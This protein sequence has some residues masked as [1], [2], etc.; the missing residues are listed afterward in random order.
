MD[1]KEKLEKCKFYKGE[2]DPYSLFADIPYPAR[3]LSIAAWKGEAMWVND[4]FSLD[5]AVS[6]SEV[7][8]FDFSSVAAPLDLAVCL[9]TAFRSPLDKGRVEPLSNSEIWHRFVED[10]VPFYINSMVTL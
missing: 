9:F 5:D 3:G 4:P 7:F 2:D 8:G 10:F 6:L 1:K